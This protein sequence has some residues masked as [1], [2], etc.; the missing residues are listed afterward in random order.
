MDEVIQTHCFGKDFSEFNQIYHLDMLK[1]NLLHEMLECY[2]IIN[3]GQS[4]HW[5]IISDYRPH[6]E[7]NQS[8]ERIVQSGQPMTTVATN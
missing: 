8:K 6:K 5:I 1:C 4:L 2:K 7:E 3:T